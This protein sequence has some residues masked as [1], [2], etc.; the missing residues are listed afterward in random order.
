M[1]SPE[2]SLLG[3]IPGQGEESGQGDGDVK[4]Y[5]QA[6]VPPGAFAPSCLVS[7]K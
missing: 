5:M 6:I 1:G 3:R 7:H 2:K 4:S